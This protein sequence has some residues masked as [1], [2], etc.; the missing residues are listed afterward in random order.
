M[1]RSMK[2]SEKIVNDKIVDRILRSA[3]PK[4]LFNKQECF[5]T[6]ALD[7]QYRAIGRAILVAIGTANSVEVYVRDAFREALK[8][9]AI[10][11]IF[12]HNHPSGSLKPSPMDEELTK[13]LEESGKILGIQILDNIIMTRD[14]HISRIEGQWGTS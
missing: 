1:A 7:T 14:G 9:N 5:V 12:V 11:V 6:L 4:R 10:A 2:L 13:R 8:R 3:I